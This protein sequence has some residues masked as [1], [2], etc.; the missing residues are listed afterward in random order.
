M[1]EV[2]LELQ[3]KLNTDYSLSFLPFAATWVSSLGAS[4]KVGVL[5]CAKKGTTSWEH[6]LPSFGVRMRANGRTQVRLVCGLKQ[7]GPPDRLR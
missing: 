5:I 4:T 2:L 7:V 1:V 3:N 6:T